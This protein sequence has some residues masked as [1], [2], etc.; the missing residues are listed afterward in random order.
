MSK[1]FLSLVVVGS[2]FPG[3]ISS[4]VAAGKVTS[5]ICSSSAPNVT[6]FELVRV[7]S[8]KN[9]AQGSHVVS[10]SVNEGG[11]QFQGM[12]DTSLKRLKV[13]A[14]QVDEDGE[15]GLVIASVDGYAAMGEHLRMIFLNPTGTEKSLQTIEMVCN[16]VAH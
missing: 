1:W 10:A 9:R 13:K 8:K 6:G 3:L 14:V 12:Y 16:V 2:I 7:S 4:A 15:A 5:V 11:I